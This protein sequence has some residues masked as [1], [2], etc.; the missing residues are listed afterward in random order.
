M[1]LPALSARSVSAYHEYSNFILIDSFRS[2]NVFNLL[3]TEDCLTATDLGSVGMKVWID[4]LTPKHALFFE[5]LYRDLARAGHKLLLTTRTYREAEEALELKRLR[6]R[7]VGEHGG[8]S[9]YG[10]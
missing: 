4:I 6:F 7:V 8:A 9:R 10:K 5:P 1:W 3:S 2:G